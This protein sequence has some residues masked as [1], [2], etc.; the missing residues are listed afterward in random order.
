MIRKILNSKIVRFVSSLVEWV[1]GV[2]LVFLVCLTL[3]QS[4]SKQGDFF[5]YRVYIV[6]SESMVPLYYVGDTLLV[7][8]MPIENIEVGDTVTYIGRYEGIEDLIITHQLKR[9]E[10]DSKGNYLLHIKGIANDVEDPIV[11]EDQILGKV[12]YKFFILSLLG[13]IITNTTLTIICITVP[14]VILILIEIIKLLFKKNAD[15]YVKENETVVLEKDLKIKDEIGEKSSLEVDNDSNL[16]DVNDTENSLED[17]EED[18]KL[19]GN[20]V[21]VGNEF[22]EL[23]KKKVESNEVKEEGKDLGLK[24]NES[25]KMGLK[26]KDVAD[27]LDENNK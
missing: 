4:V 26:I 14:I 24:N 9:K 27:I 2:T 23:P 1:I 20:F 12:V 5:G 8:E 19:K 16:N 22:I 18:L 13:K 25:S 11:Y 21:K 10:T 17:K 6:G 7:K 15:V 3:F